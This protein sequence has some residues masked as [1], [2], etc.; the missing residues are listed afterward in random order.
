M[1]T[2]G[3]HKLAAS[4]HVTALVDILLEIVVATAVL[5]LYILFGPPA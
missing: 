1:A 2:V 5:V 3:R 4:Q